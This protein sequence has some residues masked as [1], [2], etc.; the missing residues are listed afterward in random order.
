M[1]SHV[2]QFAAHLLAIYM[3]GPVRETQSALLEKLEDMDKN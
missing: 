2:K 1:Y 3:G